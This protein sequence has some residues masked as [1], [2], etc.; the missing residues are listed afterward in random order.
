MKDYLTSLERLAK[1]RGR[2]CAD[3]EFGNRSAKAEIICRLHR[4]FNQQ[5][6]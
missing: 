5:R 1:G 2:G 4:H 3:P 6:A